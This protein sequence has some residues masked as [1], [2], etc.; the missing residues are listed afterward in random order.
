MFDEA[1][2]ARYLRGRLP[3]F[4]GPLTVRQFRGGQSNPTFQL[5]TP[6]GS[7]VLRKKPEGPL[8]A[9][10]HAVE[11][12]AR[13]L[14]ALRT[15]AVP[16]PE[17]PLVCD[18]ASVIGTAFY[19]MQFVP[20]RVIR[21][22]ELPELTPADRRATYLAAVDALAAVHEVDWAAVGLGD[23]GKPNGYVVRQIERW[24]K[25]VRATQ[26]A[27]KVP[28]LEWLIDWLPDHVPSTPSA[29]TIAHGDFRIDN[30]ILHPSEPRVVAVLDWELSTLG[31]P[32]TD[33]A[34]FCMPYLLPRRETGLRGLVGADLEALG[35]PSQQELVAAYVAR[36]GISAPPPDAWR[37]YGAFGLFRMA[38]IV[39]GIAERVALGNA[40]G[41][42]AREVAAQATTFAAAGRRLAE[43]T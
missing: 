30:L 43:G 23:F 10:A 2:L 7:W 41:A 18:D 33:L 42:N 32:L 17:V 35:I 20:G 28:D 1:A 40:S 11:R 13:V 27:P 38:A 24:S 5:E 37:F 12:E 15:T 6:T 19:V 26:H 9:S 14:M 36:R 3:G 16:V 8:L 4:E 39:T 34:Y 25:Q 21:S 22:P 29:V 31:E